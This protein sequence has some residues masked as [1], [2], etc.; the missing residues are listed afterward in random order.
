M[1]GSAAFAGR[2]LERPGEPIACPIC[3]E[4]KWA[5]EYLEAVRQDVRLVRDVDGGVRVDEW[6]GGT[7]RH[8]DGRT[9][10]ECY[11]CL[12]CGEEVPVGAGNNN[13]PTLPLRRI[14]GILND[15]PLGLAALAAVAS[16]LRDGG[17]DVLD[18]DEDASE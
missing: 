18:A 7:E 12:E 6:L 17:V 15:R 13:H 3:G 4:S 11:R 16:V 2:L 14:T 1:A 8:H 10:E 5:A 9:D